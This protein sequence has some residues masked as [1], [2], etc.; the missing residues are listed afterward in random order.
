MPLTTNYNTPPYYDDYD[1]SKNFHRVLFRPQVA[2]QARELTQ[3]QTILQSQIERFGS[4]IF[5]DGSV[6]NGCQAKALPNFN[7]VRVS[8]YFLDNINRSILDINDEMLLVGATSNVRAVP[9]ITTEGRIS[10]YPN[11]NVFH[12]KYL[13]T[14]VNNASTFQ[15]GEEIKVYNANQNKLGAIVANNYID[16]LSVITSN[17]TVNAIGV[18]YGISVQDGLIFQ[19]G[20]FVKV[21]PHIIPVRYFD[22]NVSN[23]VIGFET[24][25]SIITEE[26]DLTL[27]DNAIGY[28]NE[29][30][31]GAHRIKLLPRMVAKD[32]SSI[33]NNS[34]F[35][36]VFEF[37]PVD[38]K[39]LMKNND[40]IYAKLGD[41]MAQRTMEESGNYTINPF[42]VETV[43]HKTDPT[44]F[45]YVIDPGIAY[46]GGR[47][48]EYLTS[49]EIETNRATDTNELSQQINTINFGNYVEVKELSGSFDFDTFE[50]VQIYNQTQQS[51]TNRRF[52][53]A[54]LGTLIGT[55]QIRAMAYESGTKGTP[56]AK[57]LAYIFNIRMNTGYSFSSDAKSLYINNASGISSA[58]IVTKSN[59]AVIEE[60]SKNFL[61]F[62]F[63]KRAIKRLRSANGTI[64]RSEFITRKS[65]SATLQANGFISVTMSPPAAGGIDQLPY[66]VGTLTDTLEGSFDV[67]LSANTWSNNL[68]GTVNAS[69]SN[70]TLVGSG[71]NFNLFSNNEFIKITSGGTIDYRRVVTVNSA[72]S[73]LLD[74]APSVSNSAALVAK[75]YPAGY[76][77]PLNN[78][79]VGTRNIN[80][81]SST[82][83]EINTGLAAGGNLNATQNVI[84]KYDVNRIQAVQKAKNL[85]SNVY[86]KLHANNHT[87]YAYNLGLTDVL[88][89]SAVYAGNTYSESNPNIVSSFGL[90]NGQTDSSYD[91][92]TLKLKTNKIGS[93][94]N[95]LLL[96]KL[97]RFVSNT[98][99]GIGFF[100]VDSYPVNDSPSANTLISI[101]TENIPVYRSTSGV[102]IDLRDAIDFRNMKADTANNSTTIAGAT[103]NPATSNTYGNSEYFPKPDTNFQ[104]DIE[105][106]LGRIDIIN[107]NNM[108]KLSVITGVS[109]ENPRTPDSDKDSMSIAKAYIPPYPSLTSRQLETTGR[110]DYSIKTS[111]LSSKGYPMRDIGVL[112]ERIKRL[113]YY[114]TLNTLEQSAKDLQITDANGLSRFKNGIFAEPFN[115]HAF[116]DTQNPEYRMSIDSDIGVAR[117]LFK[118]KNVDLK[119]N[120]IDSS[121]IKVVGNKALI[122]FTD[123]NVASQPYASKY[124]NCCGDVWSWSGEITLYPEY[125]MNRDETRLPNSDV[126][127]DLTQPFL[128]FA[129]TV[130]EAT[131]SSIFG[132]RWGDWRTTSSSVR[133][134]FETRVVPGGGEWRTGVIDVITSSTDVRTGFSSTINSMTNEQTFGRFVK[135]ISIQPYMKSRQIAFVARNLKPNTRMYAFFDSTAVSEHCAPG[136]LN[137][138]TF[139]KPDD[140]VL[141][142]ANWGE[143]LITDSTGNLIGKF[144]LPEGEFRVGDRT[145]MLM[146]SDSIEQGLDA[147]ITSAKAVFTA[148][149]IRM[150]TSD[151]NI[152]TTTPTFSNE[153]LTDTRTREDIRRIFPS[154]DPIAQTYKLTSPDRR[155]GVYLSKIRLYFKS[156][157]PTLGVTVYLVPTIGGV[158]KDTSKLAS[159]YLPSAQVSVSDDSSEATEFVFPPVYHEENVE[160]AFVVMPEANSPDYK[161]FLSE[162]GKEDLITGSQVFTSPYSGVALRSSNAST[163]TPIQNE[164]IKFDIFI[165]NFKTST[166]TAMFENENDEY[167]SFSNYTQSNN[168]VSV[169]NGDEIYPINGNNAITNTAIK[170]IIQF[171]DITSSEAIID[172][173]S[174]NFT[175]NQTYGIFRFAQS[176]NTSLASN[177]TLISKLTITSLNNLPVDAGVLHLSTTVPLTTDVSAKI[178]GYSNT[179]TVDTSYTPV[180]IDIEK[181]NL[182]LERMIYSRSNEVSLSLQKSLKANVTLKSES[183]WLSPILNLERKSFLVIENI[184]NNDL[185]NEETNNGAALFKYLCSPIILSDGQDA[186][187]LEVRVTGWRPINTNINVYCRLLNAEDPDKFQNKT[188]TLMTN[189][190]PEIYSASGDQKDYRE[191]KFNIPATASSNT[192]AWTNESNYNVV[193]YTDSDGAKYVGFKT[194][195]IK[196]VGTSSSKNIIPIF[197]SVTAIA[198]QV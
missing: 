190:N 129:N 14:G 124:R 88:R 6:V 59:K 125:D 1:E 90:Q 19:K 160:Y 146:D 44:K 8:D 86:V 163:W 35:F 141:K 121:G 179:G 150:S 166:A 122:D 119:L 66:S 78:S 165:C 180:T 191:W 171:I 94:T 161:I 37:S 107:I 138:A 170:G 101:K 71:T 178:R 158:P 96:V 57:Y 30:A 117:P 64:N 77:V 51:I 62:P 29:N 115:S 172:T 181:E 159:V 21:L 134:E 81:S 50:T 198:L 67:I 147:A 102:E 145:F 109:S 54:P 126:S 76:V 169:R 133:R 18:G 142:T 114:V 68:S 103:V 183:Q 174:G 38:N 162:T 120:T 152:T 128:D 26:T 46:I 65:S 106:Y 52:A 73:M 193:E 61:V 63:G 13:T 16:K 135:D 105:Y 15:P 99:T 111:I 12:I 49:N 43:N 164:D 83:F 97:D 173:S 175:A 113:E 82:S 153:V 110:K 139:T 22:S 100:S 189:S 7:Y 143:P 84:V 93:L 42:M 2:V 195:A 131:G 154:G 186:E 20:F 151:I 5:K 11:T 25:E 74:A 182:D 28:P 123:Y 176:G 27:Y 69:S 85:I 137:T 17:S 188:W 104:A 148:S 144:L 70:T 168:S 130:S 36:T 95:E 194:Y 156:K 116:G 177:S 60:S 136:I 9:V 98:S 23:T 185:S 56:D 155:G 47:R 3:L 33:A 132:T 10:Q 40:P 149:N 91:H 92:G 45:K 140:A 79:L 75:F 34:S 48:V 31:P 187:D 192:A 72:T 89:I 41:V 80:I 4:H 118:S 87:N 157:D 32:K 197:N 127:I 55:A 24:N 112:D 58:D 196:I 53:A 108:G 39:I 167:I 184:I